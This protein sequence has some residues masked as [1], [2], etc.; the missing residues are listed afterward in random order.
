VTGAQPTLLRELTHA[1]RGGGGD[2]RRTPTSTRCISPIPRLPWSPTG[3]PS[4]SCGP[5]SAQA[6][7]SVCASNLKRKVLALINLSCV[8]CCQEVYLAGSN[9]VKSGSL[10]TPLATDRKV[11]WL[12][13][14]LAH[15]P[16]PE[17][18]RPRGQCFFLT[19]TGHIPVSPLIETDHVLCSIAADRV[20]P[21]IRPS[22]GTPVTRR[23]CFLIPALPFRDRARA[24]ARRAHPRLRPPPYL[25][26]SGVAAPPMPAALRAALVPGDSPVLSRR[27][28]STGVLVASEVRRRL[29]EGA[30]EVRLEIDV[31]G[32][33]GVVPAAPPTRLRGVDPSATADDP[34]RCGG[35]RRRP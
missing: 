35:R 22:E 11:P 26:V 3:S 15:M 19:A 23:S 9:V 31:V 33:A 30:A 20:G 25:G 1:R 4:N 5:D 21:P 7:G 34:A 13:N 16:S 32:V 28:D 29:R 18:P 6:R 17:Q 14:P 12:V 8:I 27:P 10:S 2:R 24:G